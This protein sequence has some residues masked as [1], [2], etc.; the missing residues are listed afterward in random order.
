MG[1]HRHVGGERINSSKEFCNMKTE[2]CLVYVLD[3]SGKPLMPT[4]RFGKVRRLLDSGKAK[5]VQTIP[6]TIQLLYEPDTHYVQPIVLGI[7]PGREHIGLTATT[8]KGRAVFKARFDTH[9]GEVTKHMSKR[10]MYRQASRHG[11]RLRR[12]R[13]AK[14]YGTLMKCGEVDRKLPGYENGT[15]KVKGILNTEARF[16]NRKRKPGW[17]TPTARHLLECHE[18]IVMFVERIIPIREISIEVARFDFVAMSYPNARY[19]MYGNGP[20]KGYDSQLEAL[21]D[22]QK[23]KC[24][25]CQKG[26]VEQKHHMRPRSLGGSDTLGNLVGLCNSCH[27]KIHQ[28]QGKALERLSKKKEGFNKKY[29]AASVLNQIMGRFI[30]WCTDRYPGKVTL[31]DGKA[32]KDYRDA[33]GLV[34]DH[35]VDAQCIAMCACDYGTEWDGSNLHCYVIRKYRRHDR[36]RVKAQ[37]SRTYKIG[38]T[39]VAKNRKPAMVASVARDGKMAYTK[40]KEPA[41]SDWYEEQVQKHGEQEA[42][43]MRSQLVVAPSYRRY[44]DVKRTLPGTIFYHEGKRYVKSGQIRPDDSHLYYQAEGVDSRNFPAKDCR[45]F[46]NKGIVVMS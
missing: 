8:K 3:T 39:T 14:K 28:K 18:N 32:T 44:N 24:L 38:K 20:M 29:A 33:H 35:H 46:Y 34:K 30:D 11:E 7:D 43:R 23:G 10:R 31:T 9:N 25:L 41:L 15:V 22:I 40:Q 13:R 36:A 6:F 5:V 26:P 19:Q 17:M 27:D 4:K 21:R 37:V 12:K 45:I 42:M 1:Y 2:T 16:N